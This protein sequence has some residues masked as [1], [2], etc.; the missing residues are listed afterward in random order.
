[1]TTIALER[2]YPF[3]HWAFEIWKLEYGPRWY[4]ESLVL[5]GDSAENIA[6]YLGQ[7]IKTVTTYEKLFFDVRSKINS[8]GYIMSQIITKAVERGLFD[9]EH[10]FLWKI[11]GITLGPEG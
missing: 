6:E 1:N 10:D 11:I 2:A 5:A 8:K 4:I 9:R 3:I 7:D